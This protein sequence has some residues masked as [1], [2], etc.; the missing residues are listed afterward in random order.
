VPRQKLAV[1]NARLELAR[2]AAFAAG[3][4]LGGALVGWTGTAPAFAFAAGLSLLA[5]LVLASVREPA[6]PHPPPPHPLHDVREGAAFVLTHPLLRPIVVTAVIFNTSFFL[7]QAAY[8][9]YAVHRLTISPSGVGVTLA[10]YG[11]GMVAGA[12]VVAHVLRRLS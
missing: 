10:A 11:I 2:S 9:P 7:L 3:P 8:V 12:L 1:A 5:V 4:A 6:P